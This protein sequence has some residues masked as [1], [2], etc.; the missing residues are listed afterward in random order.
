[1]NTIAIQLNNIIKQDNPYIM[2]MLSELGR[3]LFFP[4]GILSQSAEA[5]AKAYNINAT[6]GN[7]FRMAGSVIALVWGPSILGW[8][9]GLR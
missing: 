7:S 4:K 6:I 8:Y 3:N 5:K 2:E 1:M 9:I